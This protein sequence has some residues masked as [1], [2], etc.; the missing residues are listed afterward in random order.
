MRKALF[1]WLG[2]DPI[3]PRR[4]PEIPMAPLR[5]LFESDL[6]KQHRRNTAIDRDLDLNA[7][8]LGRQD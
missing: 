3:E 1:E 6:K 8:N 5:T 4:H 7:R 2:I